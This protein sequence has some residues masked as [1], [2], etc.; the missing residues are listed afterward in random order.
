MKIYVLMKQGNF[1]NEIVTVSTD[2]NK[3]RKSICEDFNAEED[4]PTLS[5]WLNEEKI[6]EVSG[7]VVLYK[8]RD[9]IR[10]VEGQ[11]IR[12]KT[13]VEN[14]AKDLGCKREYQVNVLRELIYLVYEGNTTQYGIKSTDELEKKREE[15]FGKEYNTLEERILRI[16]GYWS[17]DIEI[18]LRTS[19]N[20]NE[21][22][23]TKIFSFLEDEKVKQNDC[24]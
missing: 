18:E 3:I 8:I 2:I 10:L 23:F 7:N 24:I 15:L 4:Y 14:F 20:L 6:E 9:E 19:L 12:M 13:T 22:I 5:I 17:N 1:G 21:S 16:S 11:V